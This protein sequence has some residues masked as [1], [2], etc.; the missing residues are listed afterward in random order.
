VREI[1]VYE[2]AGGLPFFEELVDRFYGRVAEDSVVLSVYPNPEDLGPARRRLTLF[3]AEYWG[4]PPTYSAERGH[5]RHRMR[6]F[7]FAI[8]AAE[9]DRWLEHMEAAVTELAP[10]PQIA[11]ALLT[12][13]RMGVKMVRNRE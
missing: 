5:P 11:G 7:P 13:F 1:S 10:P 12:Y 4:G 8:G 9:R 3:L 6:H 2:A